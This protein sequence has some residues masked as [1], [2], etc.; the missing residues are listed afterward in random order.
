MYHVVDVSYEGTAW[1]P[2]KIDLALA[3][4]LKEHLTKK[5]TDSPLTYLR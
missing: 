1:C 3:N 4:I 2:I 5:I